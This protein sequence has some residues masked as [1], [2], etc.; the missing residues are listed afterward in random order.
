[1]DLFFTK[2]D[3]VIMAML[4]VANVDG[5]IHPDETRAILERF[6]PT[7]VAAVRRKFNNMNDSEL[8][9]CLEANKSEFAP[10]ENDRVRLVDDLRRIVEADGK[11]SPIEDY[12]VN[13]VGDLLK[14]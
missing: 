7:A 4:Y 14:R 6:E 1:M 11:C 5:K 9:A 8:L 13:A 3:F 10:T 12:V 2:E